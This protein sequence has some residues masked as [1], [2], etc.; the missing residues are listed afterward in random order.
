MQTNIIIQS[1]LLKD[2][3]FKMADILNVGENEIL[4]GLYDKF[5][6]CDDDLDIILDK[7]REL[8]K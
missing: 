8:I 5:E 1:E 2:C 7:T 6:N 3:I 4:D